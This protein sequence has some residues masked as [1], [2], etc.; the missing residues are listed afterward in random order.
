MSKYIQEEYLGDGLYA[1]WDGYQIWLCANDKCSGN[2][3]DVVALEPEV[4]GAF[5]RYVDRLDEVLAIN[6]KEELSK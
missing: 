5:D 3:S 1:A 6:A 2:T 4:L